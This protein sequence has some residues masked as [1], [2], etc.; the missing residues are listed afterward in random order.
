MEYNENKENKDLGGDA[1]QSESEKV[2][3]TPGLSDR[4]PEKGSGLVDLVVKYSGGLIKNKRQASYVVL[5]FVA[6]IAAISI[7]LWI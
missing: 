4:Y 5:A 7:L 3:I 1:G 2:E 6:L